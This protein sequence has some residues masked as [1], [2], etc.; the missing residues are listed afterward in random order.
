MRRI[1]ATLSGAVFSNGKSQVH[2]ACV[3]WLCVTASRT[4]FAIS[5]LSLEWTCSSVESS[6]SPGSASSSLANP[7]VLGS[8]LKPGIFM[9]LITD[10]GSLISAIM[11]ASSSAS[12]W[13]ILLPIALWP[14]SLLGSKKLGQKL[15]TW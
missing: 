11:Q 4:I 9:F 12:G 2:E 7:P 10:P 5:H 13:G 3:F 6:V 15:R 8:G 1:K 14:A